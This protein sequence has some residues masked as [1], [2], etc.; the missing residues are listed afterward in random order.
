MQV[1]PPSIRKLKMHLIKKQQIQV[2]LIVLL[3]I[4]LI[5]QLYKFL[6]PVA[7]VLPPVPTTAVKQQANIAYPTIPTVGEPASVTLPKSSPVALS[8][9]ES[10]STEYTRLSSELQ[11]IQMKRAIAESHEAI[12]VAKRNTAKAMA[13]M[14]Q[15][16]GNDI[17]MPSD[18][19]I[20]PPSFSNDYELIYTGQEGGQWTATL[21]K[22][23]QT[24]DV[25]PNTV[26]GN[27]KVVSID[28]NSVTVMQGNLRKIIT[29]NGIIPDKKMPPIPIV[30][31]AAIQPTMK[32]IIEGANPEVK[33]R[34]KEDKKEVLTSVSTINPAIT[35]NGLAFTNLDP[36]HFTIQLIA[37]ID[38]H[39]LKQFIKKHRLMDNTFIVATK[40]SGKD[41]YVLL[42]GDY[43][44]AA[45]AN[46]ALNKLDEKILTWKPF[47]RKIGSI[48]T[49]TN[50]MQ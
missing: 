3:V 25:V 18:S 30:A 2:A 21:M 13:E 7:E 15:I 45:A 35:S 6:T 41:W 24:F 26:L 22:N 28:D 36:T 34:P 44:S 1:G 48:Q 16:A 17:A 40:K 50:G 43:P 20:V 29:F 47:V 5:W 46:T 12:A 23:N 38:Q 9:L 37:D 31:T 27:M 42:Y 4:I 11:L 33:T 8:D 39:S 49:S 32:V 10:P 14:A 19:I